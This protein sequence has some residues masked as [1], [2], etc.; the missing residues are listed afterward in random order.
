MLAAAFVG[1][2][3]EN[4]TYEDTDAFKNKDDRNVQG[5]AVVRFS[6]ANSELPFP[7]DI[8]FSGT[9]DGSLNIPGTANNGKVTAPTNAQ[10][11]DPQV[12][13]NTLDGFSTTSPATFTVTS[14][15]DASTLADNVLVYRSDS[16]QA[17]QQAFATANNNG[18]LLTEAVPCVGYDVSS[19]TTWSLDGNSEAL[20]EGVDYVVNAS[21][22]GNG[23]TTVAILPLAPLD[24]SSTYVIGVKDGIALA[25][26][27]NKTVGPDVEYR[28]LESASPVHYLSTDI[29]AELGDA[30]LTQLA[31]ATSTPKAVLEANLSVDRDPGTEGVQRN[32]CTISGGLIQKINAAAPGTIDFSP[33]DDCAPGVSLLTTT[34]QAASFESLRIQVNALEGAL[35]N[36]EGIDTDEL[37][38]A[39]SYSTQNIGGALLQAKAVTTETVVT[40]V[41]MEAGGAPGA[42]PVLSED[43]TLD[44]SVLPQLANPLPE[45]DPDGPGTG[46]PS[47]K[48]ADVVLGSFNVAPQFLNPNN[49][50]TSIWKGDAN[51]WADATVLGQALGSAPAGSA[52]ASACEQN[53]GADTDSENLVQCNAYRPAVNTVAQVPFVAVVPNTNAENIIGCTPPYGVVI[54]QHGI[55]SNRGTLLAMGNTLGASCKIG[56]A[57]DMPQHGI[58]DDDAQFGA[59]AQATSADERLVPG[60]TSGE[61]FINLTNL[62]NARDSIRQATTD[63]NALFAAVAPDAAAQSLGQPAPNLPSAIELVAGEAPGALIDQTDIN[64][65]G[66]S[67]GAIVGTPFVAQSPT[68]N[69][70]VLNAGGGGIAKILDGSP[71]FEP[72][73]TE[74][75]A[76]QGIAKPSGDYES[77]IVAAQT[78]VDSGDPINFA[79]A[80]SGSTDVLVQQVM[81][82]QVVP[83]NVLGNTQLAEAFGVVHATGQTGF[84]NGQNP[85]TVP[86]ALAGTDPL[87]VGTDFV[88]VAASS[89]AQSCVGFTGMGLA[90]VGPTGAAVT[91][92]WVRY[93]SGS[94]SS[95]LDDTSDEDVTTLMQAQM[96]N[97]ITGNGVIAESDIGLNGLVLD[98]S[99][100]GAPGDLVYPC[101]I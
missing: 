85:V 62:A 32:S 75:L 42:T 59:L 84:L 54:Y 78:M 46:A 50:L 56:I 8:L 16:S 44:D 99:A 35:A 31:T 40:A 48:Y 39:F 23:G 58:A 9:K 45:F 72:A 36:A 64:F 17:Q 43:V 74:G 30:A 81:G 29:A 7:T 13:L 80:A 77:F 41:G 27:P 15:I 26:E 21:P 61:G 82:D 63:L 11:S 20:T 101:A 4:N 2:S 47:A 10:A 68:L 18:C 97:F 28:L 83:N 53:F 25:A 66:I 37:V 3:N 69:S 86:S 24:S 94:H 52:A 34:E 38:A 96:I 98:P 89:G 19:K 71:R 70:A 88:A 57:I 76:E 67:L 51:A 90:P 87:A 91:D 95:L 100:G 55:T 6:P 1:C 5:A 14:E 73:I 65:V 79:A 60:L 12:A 93:V 22:N 92:G 49:P 33:A